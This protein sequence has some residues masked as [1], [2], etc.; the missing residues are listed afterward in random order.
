MCLLRPGDLGDAFADE[1]LRDDEL[2]LSAPG[3]ASPV[4]HGRDGVEL[5]PVDGL[6]VEADGLEALRG[7][8]A[9]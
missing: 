6:H 9:L 7:V 5:V 1:R 3:L 8:F 4:K 2:G